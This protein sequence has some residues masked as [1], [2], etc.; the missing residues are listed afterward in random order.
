[1]CQ[2]NPTNY[3]AEKLSFDLPKGKDVS[4][5]VT[6]QPEGG[7]QQ[8]M[9]GNLIGEMLDAFWNELSELE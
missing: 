4:I 3:L 1:M 6:Y 2:A 5:T 9:L 8:E 7:K